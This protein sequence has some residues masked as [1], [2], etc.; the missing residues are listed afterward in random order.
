VLGSLGLSQTDAKVYIYL[1]TNGPKKARAIIDYLNINRGQVY[2]SLRRL[3][4]KG[5]TVSSNE[6][7]IKFS[8]VPFE[9]V[10]DMLMK[11]KKEQAEILRDCKEE[12]ILDFRT[13][14][15]NPM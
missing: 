10:L 15:K 3:Q 8:A 4:N 11:I 2:K 9:D 7:P 13:E 6:H 14:K 5:A 12:L 1:A